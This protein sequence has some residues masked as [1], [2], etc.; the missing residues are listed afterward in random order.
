MTRCSKMPEVQ[1]SCI[2]LRPALHV[3]E[4]VSN[5]CLS[6]ELVGWLVLF[7]QD[8]R[9]ITRFMAGQDLIVYKYVVCINTFS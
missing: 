2:G 4:N 7:T 5:F 9:K 6:Y 1:C 8:A 3:R